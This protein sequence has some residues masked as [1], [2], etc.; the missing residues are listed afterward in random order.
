[1]KKLLFGLFIVTALSSCKKDLIDKVVA[2][3]GLTPVNIHFSID[4]NDYD[5]FYIVNTATNT[6]YASGVT[7]IV[8]GDV[9]AHDT[10]S[11]DIYKLIGGDV[12]SPEPSVKGT[13]LINVDRNPAVFTDNSQTGDTSL[14]KGTGT[15]Y[16]QEATGIYSNI[17][18]GAGTLTYSEIL[19]FPGDDEARAPIFTIDMD[20]YIKDK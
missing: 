7:R 13:I 15:W 1:M 14:A 11:N 8:Q 4:Q 20:G 10:A 9:V 5:K 12:D 2:S 6:E 16:I 18:G 17:K 3:K 19:S